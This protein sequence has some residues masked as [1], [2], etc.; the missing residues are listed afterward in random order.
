MFSRLGGRFR[1]VN[2]VVVFVLVFAMSGGAF[3]ASKFLITSTKQIKP[4]VLKQLQG[5]RGAVGPVGAPGPQGPV[6]LRGEAG[7]PGVAGKEGPAGT[8]KEGPAGKE[9]SPWTAGGTLPSG[10]TE[11]G[12]WAISGS[13][14][15]HEIRYVAV[16][17][18][19]PLSVEPVAHLIGPGEG[20]GELK[21]ASAIKSGE[22]GGT[23]AEPSAG[24]GNLCIFAKVF[25]NLT[26]FPF[27]A[28]QNAETGSPGAGKAGAYLNLITL[29]AGAASGFG[30]WVV[31]AP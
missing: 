13:A 4:S 12:Q 25:T 19:I 7:A 14:A 6:G 30:T 23:V 27:N 9:G 1:F 24:P 17:Y 8:G 22:C 10:K 3:A 20:A 29:E 2:V 18:P 11:Q 21:E 16:S 15:E 5:K 26:G 31:T 28:V